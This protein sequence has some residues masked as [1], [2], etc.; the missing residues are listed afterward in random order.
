MFFSKP[1]PGVFDS[2]VGGF[3]VYK[4]IRKCTTV[5][6]IYYG[7]TL[8]APYGN[9][10]EE[11]IVGLLK[12]SIIFLQEKDVT[13]FVNAC[14][15]MSVVVTDLLL[16]SRH[17][18]PHRY[19][20]MIRAFDMHATC[21][22]RDRVLVIAT[23]ATIRSGVY[24]KSIEEK[25]A[26]VFVYA[27][28]DLAQAIEHNASQE[29]LYNLVEKSIINAKQVDA[30]HIVYGCTHYPLVHQLFMLA[31]EKHG[32]EGE[33][34]DPA[35]Y[36]ANVVEGWKLEGGKKFYPHASKDTPAFIN[37]IIKLL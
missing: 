33:F 4:E 23:V 22:E 16:K 17:I 34:I 11:E 26:E 24:Q 37:N 30:T 32:W 13:H 18:A 1:L 9:K 15:S 10:E 29:V 21:G 27:Y 5:N 31:K 20:D 3:S 19:V 2:G 28:T 6:S 25:G 14:N 12:E 35:V 7:D 36:V 8:R